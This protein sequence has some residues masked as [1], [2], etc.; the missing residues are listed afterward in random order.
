M[1]EARRKKRNWRAVL[2]AIHRDA[3]YACVGLTVLY[4]ISGVA[5][6]HVADWNPNYAIERQEVALG[7]IEHQSPVD[8]AAVRAI[9]AQLELPT[10]FKTKFQADADS[11]RV[12]QEGVTVD[13]TLSTG[14]GT[15]VRT[16]TRPVIHESNVLHL[17]HPKG[18]WTYVADLFAVALAFLALSGMLILKGRQGLL[19]RG[20]WFTLG[21][22]AV[23]GVFLYLY[24]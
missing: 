2:R 19:G 21:G 16:S 22:I 24:L 5:V 18:A 6:N 13:L 1:A 14:T 12:I 9:L 23:P 4:A 3:G 8:D 11:L 7:P 20:L 17:N 15:L 10:G